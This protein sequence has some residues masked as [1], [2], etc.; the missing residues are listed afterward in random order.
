MFLEV[1]ELVL[2][3]R[4]S[5]PSHSNCLTTSLSGGGVG[6]TP[7]TSLRVKRASA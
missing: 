6:D 4:L 2:P 5:Q 3:V 1:M 7:P